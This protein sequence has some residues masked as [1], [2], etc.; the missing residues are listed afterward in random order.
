MRVMLFV[1]LALPLASC[2]RQL[3]NDRSGAAGSEV[4][5]PRGPY[6]VAEDP[7]AA[8]PKRLGESKPADRTLWDLWE[9][10]VVAQI[11]LVPRA[12]SSPLVSLEVGLNRLGAE[13]WELVQIVGQSLVFKRPALR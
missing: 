4:S 1:L 11:D 13:G 3:R 10:R 6:L 2:Q 9:Y 12:A 5:L 7:S 8:R